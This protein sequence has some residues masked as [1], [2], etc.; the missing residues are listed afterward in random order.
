M[1]RG[2]ESSVL[3]AIRTEAYDER[4]WCV[5]EIVWAEEA[6][7]PIIVVDARSEL[8]Y[9][10]STS[11]LEASPWVLVPDGSLTRILIC[12]LRENMRLLLAQRCVATLTPAVVEATVLLPESAYL[13]FAWR[14]AVRLASVNSREKYVV[15]PDPPLRQETRSYLNQMARA[16]DS[17]V[18]VLSFTEFTAKH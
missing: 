1:R 13:E 16:M 3:V 14:G 11:A 2:V 18:S 15:Y 4:A 5:Q 9:P 10:P 8:F 12:T 7:S 6:G 17:T